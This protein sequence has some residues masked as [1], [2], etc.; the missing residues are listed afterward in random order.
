MQIAICA[1]LTALLSA[2]GLAQDQVRAKEILDKVGSTYASAVQWD[3]A[4]T[5]TSNGG[6]GAQIAIRVRIAGKEPAQR[7]VE[8]E[9]VGM[10]PEPVII[11]DGQNVWVYSAKRNQYMQTPLSQELPSA[12]DYFRVALLAYQYS[13]QQA[14]DASLFPDETID[15]EGSPADCYVVQFHQTGVTRKWWIDKRRYV[16]LRD[17]QISSPDPEFVG[18]SAVW[19]KVQ[20]SE[21]VSDD[22]FHFTPPPGARQVQRI[23]P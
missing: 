20:L 4:G 23:D 1:S 22:L 18:S 13:P 5:I 8:K 2:V 3:M 7:R 10:E 21:P 6:P 17:D 9:N 19:K 11:V 14:S 12:L 15:A 16:V